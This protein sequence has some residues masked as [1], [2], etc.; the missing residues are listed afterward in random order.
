MFK[1]KK[2]NV[3]C[4]SSKPKSI[5]ASALIFLIIA[6]CTPEK[7]PIDTEKIQPPLKEIVI[8]DINTTLLNKQYIQ[9][10]YA[11]MQMAL[12]EINSTGGVN[13]LP[14][15]L[16]ILDDMGTYLEAYAKA[17]LAHE[18]YKAL[19]L[20]G[21]YL[22]QTAEG[23]ARYAKE[24]Q[25]PFLNTGTPTESTI[26]GKNSSR[27]SFRLREG[28]DTHIK[29]ISQSIGGSQDVKSF[30]IVRYSNEDGEYI[31]QKLKS[32]V[33]AQGKEINFA[34]DIIIS[35]FQ[36]NTNIVSSE[37]YNSYTAGVI[38]AINGPDLEQLSLNLQR[39]STLASKK[40]YV[41][42]AGE[43]E[44]LDSL[45]E[46]LT[47]KGWIVTGF[48][49]YS[50]KTKANLDFYKK[51]NQRYKTNPRYASYLGYSSVLIIVE[52]LT[53]ANINKNPGYFSKYREKLAKM[54][55]T[56]S[57]VTPMGIIQMQKDRQSNVGTYMGNLS[58]YNTQKNQGR[59]IILKLDVRMFN[60]TYIKYAPYKGN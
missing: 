33:L 45:G 34:Q 4:C 58:P 40:V 44:W 38:I 21:T 9:H 14:L 59:N 25:I 24:N 32:A 60:S 41:M 23:V 54:L 7:K 49:W 16:V 39:S 47:P 5:V 28:Y 26:R 3:F 35:P 48:P 22:P 36:S 43:P 50:I 29:A 11:G 42:F 53:A 1:I 18:K 8:V 52:A 13:N 55:E 20:T 17:N 46:Q 37:I 30:T 51:Y 56:T 2:S 19:I 15:K 27:W 6:S 12:E 57:A 31:S 10:Y